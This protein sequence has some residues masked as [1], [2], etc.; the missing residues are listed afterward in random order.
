MLSYVVLVLGGCA[1]PT[2]VARRHAEPD[3][4]VE[5]LESKETAPAGSESSRVEGDGRGACLSDVDTGLVLFTREWEEAFFGAGDG[6][7]DSGRGSFFWRKH[8]FGSNIN[9]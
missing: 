7:V 1:V 5:E 4:V 6:C 8:G 2:A 3:V 9:S